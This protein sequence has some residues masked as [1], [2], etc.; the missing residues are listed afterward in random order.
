MLMKLIFMVGIVVAAARVEAGLFDGF[1]TCHAQTPSGRTCRNAKV[2]GSDY[3]EAHKCCKC[4]ALAFHNQYCQNCENKPKCIW[5]GCGEDGVQSYVAES[6]MR[7]NI[8]GRLIVSGCYCQS[9][10]KRIAEEVKTQKE[11]QAKEIQ[12]RQEA[13]INRAIREK[14]KERRET[15]ERQ[16]AI[17]HKEE[18]AAI[19]RAG[20]V[21][22]DQFPTDANRN[23]SERDRKVELERV[24]K[25]KAEVQK[26]VDSEQW[27]PVAVE[28]KRELVKESRRAG[29]MPEDDEIWMMFKQKAEDGLFREA[30]TNELV[31]IVS[32]KK[33]VDELMKARKF[34]EAIKVCNL[35]LLVGRCQQGHEDK[36]DKIWKDLGADAERRSSLPCDQKLAQVESCNKEKEKGER[37]QREEA[38]NEA[39]IEEVYQAAIKAGR[40]EELLAQKATKKTQGKRKGAKPDSFFGFPLGEPI[41]VDLEGPVGLPVLGVK[42]IEPKTKDYF[43]FYPEKKFRCF[44]KYYVRLSPISHKVERIV[45]Q[46]DES[47]KKGI[48]IPQNEYYTIRDI[49]EAQYGRK[50]ESRG[51]ALVQMMAGIPTDESETITFEDGSKVFVKQYMAKGSRAIWGLKDEEW[52]GSEEDLLSERLVVVF[53]DEVQT[54]AGKKE[55]KEEKKQDVLKNHKA[56]AELL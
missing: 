26:L 34:N 18:R 24:A 1:S 40:R 45:F 27:G 53:V 54:E 33:E 5:Q 39:R 6:S 15:E 17:R 50:A 37:K 28:C 10:C 55:W 48:K 23:V 3:C 16:A 8:D 4:S 12:K 22:V 21:K 44:E 36:D 46:F 14:E 30:R 56:D 19:D 47:S 25:R 11:R 51:N 31:R 52:D 20:K 49:L 35:E 7:L 13:E 42:V 29:W 9:H 32:R 41:P 38:R 43:R 2:P